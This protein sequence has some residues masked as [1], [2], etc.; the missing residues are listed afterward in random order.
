MSRQT[1]RNSSLVF[2]WHSTELPLSQIN[3]QTRPTVLPTE[4]Y[5]QSNKHTDRGK[6]RHIF[7]II[8]MIIC[9][10]LI[11]DILD[12]DMFHKHFLLPGALSQEKS[13]FWR[14]GCAKDV[15]K[16]S[17]ILQPSPLVPDVRIFF[18]LK[19]W[20]TTK[21]RQVSLHMFKIILKGSLYRNWC[22]RCTSCG[23][24][25][26]KEGRRVDPGDA[27]EG[28]RLNW[29][30]NTDQ[31]TLHTVLHY[32][33]LEDLQLWRHLL[34]WEAPFMSFMRSRTLT[35]FNLYF[36]FSVLQWSI[37]PILLH[38]RALPDSE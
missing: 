13:M 15:R 31:E 21:D 4:A 3:L 32:N 19:F 9:I 22:R 11:Y 20:L 33:P 35:F 38:N 16:F 5:I 30:W 18:K 27:S 29:W 36:L 10:Y 26:W 23:Q 8:C 6:Y 25:V 12:K 14:P 7:F 28:R 34:E 1:R 17:A 24:D 37:L 2:S